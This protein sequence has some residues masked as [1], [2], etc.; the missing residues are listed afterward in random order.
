MR[1]ALLRSAIF[2][3]IVTVL[4][5]TMQGQAG[6]Y[7]QPITIQLA[8]TSCLLPGRVWSN[9][10]RPTIQ[11]YQPAERL[12]PKYSLLFSCERPAW[13]LWLRKLLLKQIF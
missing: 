7:P 4:R 12:A 3:G 5:M 11:Q 8:I 13:F 6:F 1:N 2:G 10:T 9:I